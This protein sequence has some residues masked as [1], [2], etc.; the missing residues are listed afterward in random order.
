MKAILCLLIF[1]VITWADEATDRTAIV[2]VIAAVNEFPQRTELFTTD[3]DAPAVL[4]QLRRGKRVAYRPL[5]S[6]DHPTV[7]ISHEPWGEATINF[8]NMV[9]EILNP[10]IVSRTMRF[11]TTDVALADGACIYR[12]DGADV[13]TTPLL[14]VMKRDGDQW[15]IASVRVLR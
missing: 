12:E 14:F 4:E 13:Q 15:K 2:H 8:P 11:V 9:V 3:R 5:R 1:G 7:T 10:N 6:S